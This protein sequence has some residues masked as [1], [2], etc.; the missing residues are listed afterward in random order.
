MNTK[1]EIDSKR[2]VP[3]L[4][5]VASACSL[6][7]VSRTT[8]YGLINAGSLKPTKIGRKTLFRF[9]DLRAIANAEHAWGAAAANALCRA[10]AG[11]SS[12]HDL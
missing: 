2:L 10:Q 4:V 8:I 12:R 3:L 5:D 1:P 7:S 11:G 9:D 6:L